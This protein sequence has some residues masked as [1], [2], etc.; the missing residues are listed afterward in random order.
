MAQKK[1]ANAAK[2]AARPVQVADDYSHWK[3]SPVC[4][5]NILD[6]L[7]ISTD[8]VAANL[9]IPAYMGRLFVDKTLGTIVYE[10]DFAD[11]RLMALKD[12]NGHRRLFSQT[13]L[14]HEWGEPQAVNVNG[15]FKDIINPFP[16]PDGQ[17][18]FFAARHEAD[19][20]YTLYTTT[21]DTETNSYRTPQR[22]PYPFVSKADDLFYIEDEA[23]ELAWLVTTRRQ[24]RGMA[25]IYTMKT[26][27][28]WEYYD[29]DATEGRM[30]KR[31]AQIDRIA[32]TWTST[33]DRNRELA[34]A[35]DALYE[36]ITPSAPAKEDTDL[37]REMDNAEALKR[38][39]REM[40]ILYHNSSADNKASL[41]AELQQMEQQLLASYSHIKELRKQINAPLTEDNYD[42]EQQQIL[43]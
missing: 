25:C 4:K 18:L 37:T 17:T 19:S 38:Q 14:G 21:F 16:M 33:K 35:H 7:V 31:Y 41:A 27:H 8:D 15:D 42:T 5:V 39:L 34:E 32:D 28:P 6:S 22:L 43:P 29:A 12:A 9:Q 23:T 24:P 13:L 10:N 36:A 20:C 3:E 11:Q 2:P 30:L 1:R 26:K 40:R